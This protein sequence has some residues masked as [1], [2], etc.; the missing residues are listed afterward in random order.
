ME[1]GSYGR[2]DRSARG[3][4][5]GHGGRG[6]YGV[7][8]GH[9]GRGGHGRRGG[10]GGPP[11]EL[12]GRDIGLW[13][14]ARGKKKKEQEQRRDRPVVSLQGREQAISDML[15]KQLPVVS[16]PVVCYVFDRASPASWLIGGCGTQGN[17]G[18]WSRR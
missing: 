18:W 4:R 6:G 17:M 14:A 9:G 3:G 2:G 8:G 15:G 13:Y 10:H 5:E 1:R 11:P 16:W 7:R 12:S